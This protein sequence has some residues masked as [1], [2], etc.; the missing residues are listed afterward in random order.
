MKYISLFSGIGGFE[1]AIHNTFK[2]AKCIGYSEV[3]KFALKVYQHHFPTHTNLGDVTKITEEDI[4]ELIEGEGGCDLLV[5]G[6][7]CQ[8]LSSL[9]REN[10]SCNSEGLDGPKSGLFWNMVQVIRWIQTY[11]PKGKSLHLLIENNA[12]MKKVYKQQ[13]TEELQSTYN[14]PLSCTMLNGA[15]FGVQIR[16]RLYWTTFPISLKGIECTQTWDDVL[17]PLVEAKELCITEASIRKGNKLHPHK[18]NDTTL[19]LVASSSV[20]HFESRYNPTSKSMWQLGKHTDTERDKSIPMISNGSFEDILVD[21]RFYD[22]NH[23]LARYIHNTEREALFFLPN[24][25]VSDLCSKTRGKRL[26]GNTVIVR[27]IEFILSQFH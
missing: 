26:L 27:V 24:G 18:T 23:F 3:D 13:I 9:A 20:H 1:L 21:R 15:D 10:K 11:N 16:R 22:N 2:E 5:G 8:N 12:S 19:F 25:W 14:T 7:P 17:L 6:F 4:K